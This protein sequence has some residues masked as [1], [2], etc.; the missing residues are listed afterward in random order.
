MAN[1]TNRLFL[2]QIIPMDASLSALRHEVQRIS[3]RLQAC[4]RQLAEAGQTDRINT[5]AARME[6]MEGQVILLIS[7]LR[8][9]NGEGEL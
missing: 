1:D 6:A 9:S 8:Q 3:D 2:N 4:E 7:R 5:L